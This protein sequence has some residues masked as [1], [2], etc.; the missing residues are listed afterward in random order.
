MP[1]YQQQARRTVD[2]ILMCGQSNI[3]A[4]TN[5]G[6]PSSVYSGNQNNTNIFFKNDDY[7]SANNGGWQNYFFT[8]NNNHA[9]SLI[10]YAGPDLSIGKEY[11]TQTGRDLW[12]IKYAWNGSALVDFGSPYVSGFWQWDA[13]PANCNG[14]PHYDIMINNFVIP[15]IFKARA[16][17]IDLN[18]KA[19]SWCQGESEALDSGGT[20]SYLTYESVLI[21]MID[22]MILDLTPYGVLSANFKP[23][24][25]RINVPLRPFRTQ[26]RAAQVNVANHYSAPW[27][28]TD[29]YPLL[30][31][32]VHYTMSGQEQHGIDIATQLAL[33]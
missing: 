2:C 7:S 23:I 12:I 32:N 19:F 8:K 28:N 9:A 13:N 17:G 31:D 11:Y 14:L 16:N 26:V 10:N 18:V 4:S 29:S 21:S 30:A 15:A 24:I 25:S 27:I 20:S 3:N 5:I 6:T 1:V 22:K 33:L